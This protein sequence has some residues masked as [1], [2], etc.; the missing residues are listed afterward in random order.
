MA[1]Y[2]FFVPIV[3]G[4]E[5][6]D[7]QFVAEASGPRRAEFE[8]SRRRHGI[9]AERV[10]HQSTPQGSFAVVY[11]EADDPGQAFAGLATSTDPFDVWFREQV[12]AVHGFDMSQPPPGPLNEQVIDWS[13]A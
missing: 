7:R 12:L 2:A 4:Q 9:Q 8:A 11:L 10:W 6:A 1:A 13:D 3:P 5:E